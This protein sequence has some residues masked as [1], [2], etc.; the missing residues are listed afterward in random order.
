MRPEALS[1]LG[2]GVLRVEQKARKTLRIADRVYLMET[3]RIARSGAA[4]DFADEVAL[5]GAFLGWQASLSPS[6][7]FD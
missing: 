3:V 4:Q 5:S 1:F 2:P 7:R 6:G